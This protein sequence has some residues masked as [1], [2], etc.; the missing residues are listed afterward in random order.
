MKKVKLTQKI[1]SQNNI[2]KIKPNNLT[3]KK[4]TTNEK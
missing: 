4:K 3:L 1:I 2:Q